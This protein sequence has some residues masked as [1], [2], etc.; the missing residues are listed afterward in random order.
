MNIDTEAL[1]S[2]RRVRLG[3]TD[4]HLLGTAHVSRQSASDVQRELQ[5]GRYDAVAIEL[6]PSRH[7]ALTN[8]RSLEQMDLL[9]AIREGKVGMVAASLALSAYQQRIAEQFGIEPGAEMRAA[10]T[11][12]GKTGLPVLLI[13]REVGVTLKRVY[14]GVSWWQR[15]GLVAG[16]GGSLLSR[17]KITEQDIER[18]K[19]GDILEATFSEFATQSPA[20]FRALIAERDRFMAAKLLT[21]A[22]GRYRN[23]LVVAGAG[24]IDGLARELAVFQGDPEQAMEDLQQV[25]P[26]GRWPRI[27]PWLIVAVIL[28]GFAYGFSQDTQLG[29]RLVI[30]WIL[31]NGG[32]CALGSLLALAHPLTVVA[33]FIAAP[34]TSLNPTIGAGFVTAAV[35]TAMRKPTVADFTS[36]RT[37]TAHLKGWWRNRVARILLVFVLSTLGSAAGTYIAGFRIAEQLLS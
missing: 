21:E 1:T 14:R 15:L 8:P 26:P 23:V 5:S 35:E 22:A 12:A 20:L 17:E 11:E 13:D 18:L 25:P 24:H 6:C 32:L 36:L 30:D 27:I 29:W 2:L 33:S 19:Q 9:K 10:I 34:L 7:Q 3:Q 16:L 31:I 37:D 4:F 28:A